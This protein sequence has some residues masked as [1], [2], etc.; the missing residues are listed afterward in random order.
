MKLLHLF[1]AFSLLFTALLPATERLFPLE[2]GNFWELETADGKHR[3]EVSVSLPIMNGDRVYYSVRG[4]L[5]TR[6]LLREVPGSGVFVTD[7][8]LGT[9]SVATSFD[10]PGNPVFEAPFRPCGTV[11]GRVAA[12]REAVQ[13][14]TGYWVD[15]LRVTYD[16]AG[17]GADTVES[18][19]FVPGVGLIERTLRTTTGSR[20]YRLTT[21]RV[22]KAIIQAG[23]FALTSVIAYPQQQGDESLRFRIQ[24]LDSVG[25]SPAYRFP[26]TQRFDL[27]LST[28][29]GQKLYQYSDGK[30]FPPE[31]LPIPEVPSYHV[32][33][34]LDS[35]PGKSI[36]PGEYLVEAWF[37]GDDNQHRNG[38]TLILPVEDFG[39][40]PV[41]E[42]R[43]IFRGVKRP[44][45]SLSL[46][47]RRMLHASQH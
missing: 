42:S 15:G 47:G 36:A 11:T 12:Q 33:V 39:Q 30:I 38:A 43:A 44:G 34:P 16:Q 14:P 18:E 29:E 37:V 7:E 22:G 24:V 21:A 6:K 1:L 17:C 9:E 13:S 23:F 25:G 20:V 10:Q 5:D 32:D 40:P 46:P 8:E 35:L 45:G 27:V 26:T 3:I 41:A 28:R 4:Y 2:A 19:L 31:P